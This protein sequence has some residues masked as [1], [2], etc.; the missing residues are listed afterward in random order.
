MVYKVKFGQPIE[1]FSVVKKVAESK[2]LDFFTVKN[3]KSGIVFEY[4]LKSDDVVFG[5]G[6]AHGN[7]NKRGFRCVNYN[8]DNYYFHENAPSIYAS[9][10]FLIVAGKECFGVFFD[11]PAKATFEIDFKQ[12]GKITVVC[13]NK[14]LN[15][16]IITGKSAYDID[17]QFL[18][19]IGKSFIPPLWAFGLGQSK[20]GY[21]SQQDFE[22][23]IAGYQKN[24]LPLDYVCMDIDYMDRYIDFTINEK[25]FPN[26]KKFV[27]DCKKK[28]VNLVPIIDAGIKVEKGNKTYDEGVKNN[29][30]C[31]DKNGKNFEAYVWPG[32][33]HFVD[34]LQPKARDWFG[35]QYTNLLECGFTGFW[36]DMNEPAI[37][38]MDF[39]EAQK[40][41]KQIY[42]KTEDYCAFY[43]NLNGQKINHKD[44]HNIYGHLMT[45]ASSTQLKKLDERYLLFARSSF[46]GSHRYGGV[47]TGDNY[48]CWQHLKESLPMLCSMNMCGFLFS[49]AD[50]GGFSGN[51]TADLL[52]RWLSVSIFTPLLRIHSDANST[53]QECYS[54]GQNDKFRKIL[55]LRY[56]L[57][58]Y[59][60][61]EFIKAAMNC[62]LYLKPLAFVFPKD[63]HAQEIQDQL[64]V[65]NSIMIAPIVEENMFE[66]DVYLPEKMTK[67]LF[68]GKSFKCETL[69][70]GHHKIHCNLDEIVFFIRKNCLVPIALDAQNTQKTNLEK[71]TLLGDGKIYKQ[72]LDD[73]KTKQI[74]KKNIRILKK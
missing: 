35:K 73:G 34:F 8:T 22:N 29:F 2:T 39:F 48:S 31:K 28:G 32:K 54:F 3:K 52:L 24:K 21:K 15:V 33:T 27:S 70:S 7:L 64:F 17:R 23:V 6:E 9:H 43:H 51:C 55:A 56:R 47:W 36:N 20:W 11:T 16:Y 37:F 59:I 40:Q 57:L 38:N 12:S 42:Q 44:V 63:K 14:N 18:K 25:A 71:V 53:P 49:G 72:Y 74:L 50:T 68:D 10:N 30:F 69:E 60:Y 58:P 61:S 13:E 1:T 46:I 41:N 66:R 4:K 45:I 62:D 19:I 67:A 26:M 5:L 65:G